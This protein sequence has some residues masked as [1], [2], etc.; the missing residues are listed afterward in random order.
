MK[1]F[2]KDVIDK[3]TKHTKQTTYFTEL[4]WYFYIKKIKRYHY[5]KSYY[6]GK[7]EHERM[8]CW[9]CAKLDSMLYIPFKDKLDNTNFG[10]KKEL[11]K[12]HIE[13]A[14]NELKCETKKE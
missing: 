11:F 14:I 2:G 3:S 12:Q 4:L 13:D 6:R 5:S 8:I 1:V 9:L 7:D 10:F